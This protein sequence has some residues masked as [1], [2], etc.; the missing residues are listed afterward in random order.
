LVDFWLKFT[1]FKLIFY[2]LQSL[3]VFPVGED[4]VKLIKLFVSILETPLYRL[5]CALQNLSISFDCRPDHSKKGKFFSLLTAQKLPVEFNELKEDA[6]EQCFCLI[7]GP[8]L[9]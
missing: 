6:F 1:I 2:S 8:L 4:I 5:D 7:D 3:Q 9:I